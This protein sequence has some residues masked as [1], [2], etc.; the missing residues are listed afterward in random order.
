MKLATGV[1]YWSAGP[2][3]DAL[4]TLQL[5]ERLG[6]HSF[7]TAEAYGSDALTPLAWWGSHTERI[8]LG[9][10][11]V[12]ISARTPAAVAMAAITM[13]HL[14]EGRFILGLGV[15]GPQ[16]VEGWYGR[17]YPRPLARTREYIEIIR[18][19]LER[20]KPVSFSGDHYQMPYPG[21]MGLGK[22]LKSTVH[23]LRPDVPIYLGAEGPRNVALAAELC[24]GWLPLFFAPKDNQ[25]YVDALN[26]GFATAGKPQIGADGRI[27]ADVDFEVVC[28]MTVVPGDDIEQAANRVRPMLAL[29]MGGMGARDAN[30]HY[31]VFCRMGYQ[32]VADEVQDLY[33]NGRKQEAAATIPVELV[34]EVALIG[35]MDKIAR[36]LRRWD[37]T[38]V[39]TLQIA[40]PPKLLEAMAELVAD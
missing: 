16:V 10:G 35:P 40:G 2:P 4:E 25:F 26:A 18:A 19:I 29:Y 39:T 20:D 21:G 12:Q 17:P 30:F 32:H 24:E 33:L 7:W 9:T 38:V 14:S 1:G 5:A 37:D 13:D 8:G 6:F 28:P 31:D 15:S 3:P 27:P 22:A 34:E 36:D 11:I 23:P